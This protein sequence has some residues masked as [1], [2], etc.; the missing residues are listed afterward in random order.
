MAVALC[1]LFG[2]LALR[3][4]L[5]V[6]PAA[7]FFAAL[8]GVPLVQYA[9]GAIFFFGDAW[10]AALYLLGA[11][12]ATVTGR[13]G[14]GAWGK[15]FVA[16]LSGL[17]LA[18]ALVNCLIALGQRFAVD[19]GSAAL[20]VT[21]L[22][23]GRAPYGNLAQPNQ[24]T[25]LLAVALGALLWLH[26]EG[27][28]SRLW[29]LIASALMVSCMAMSQ[30]RAGLLL[31][32][33]ITA[34]Q[35][36]G[37]RRLCLRTPPWIG[38]LAIGWWAVSYVAWPTIVNALGMFNATSLES[39]ASLGP[40]GVMWTQLWEAVWVQPWAGWGW[41]QVSV[42]QME[43]VAA[44]PDSRF[45]EHSHNMLLDFL[46]WNG[47]PL[48]LLFL[49]GAS[50]WLVRRA[51]RVRTTEGALA[52]LVILLFVAH[53]QVEFPLDYLY[54][55]VPFGLM[56]GVF[57]QETSRRPNV[58]AIS[59]PMAVSLAVALV[60]VVGVATFDYLR[61]E[62]AYRDLRFTKARIGKPLIAASEDSPK[63]QFTQLSALFRF[64]QQEPRLGMSAEDLRWM[65][66]VA[67]RHPYVP[68][69]YRYAMAQAMHGDVQ[70]A[71]L[72]LLRMKNLHTDVNYQDAMNRVREELANGNSA[73]APLVAR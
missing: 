49:A 21:D 17:L 72:T 44:Y 12:A 71:K 62:H 8:A 4:S 67:L 51:A 42:A 53:W 25:V 31:L 10:I 37:R 5:L 20:F 45:T 57:E 43:V 38:M 65:E 33:V 47:V 60:A 13:S 61:F 9:A 35:F 41:N 18:A 11:A 28:V 14:S 24:L 56:V 54:F 59:R 19:W 32:L 39:R 55:L 23:P 30:S 64:A 16:A 29:V 50:V 63:T 48:A 58:H 69:L 27:H 1:I 15:S 52:L 7:F 73:L 46:L 34:W 40:R 36:I 66:S 6:T 26:E 22:R 70:G 2:W 3:N 68:V